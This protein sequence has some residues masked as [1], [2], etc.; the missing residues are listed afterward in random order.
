MNPVQKAIFRHLLTEIGAGAYAVGERIPT[1]LE[2]AARFSTGRMNARSAVAELKKRGLLLSR[3][4][5]GTVVART[6]SEDESSQLMQAAAYR[7]R[8]FNHCAPSNREIHWNDRLLVPLREELTVRGI[9]F[10]ERWMPPEIGKKDYVALLT[11]TIWQGCGAIVAILGGGADALLR[12]PEVLF[13]FRNHL[14]VFDRANVMPD[15]SWCNVFGINNVRDGILALDCVME[16]RPARVL[17]AT[18]PYDNNNRLQGI[19]QE[20]R[21]AGIRQC[22]D[23]YGDRAV[24]VTILKRRGE[25]YSFPRPLLPGTVFIGITDGVAAKVIRAGRAH[26]F[27]PGADYGIIAFDDDRRHRDLH[28]TTLSPNLRL[29][30]HILADEL[31]AALSGKRPPYT[32]NHRVV[33]ELVRRKTL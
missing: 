19:Y 29:I 21:L 33:S 26:G 27:E 16:R 1:E 25:E 10:E 23:N 32:T 4:R 30:A 5:I 17:V 31:I 6:L 20:E 18:L 28:L 24:P 9:E 14:H 7:I 15:C 22:M 2:L 3:R 12:D 13:P 8:V 11:E